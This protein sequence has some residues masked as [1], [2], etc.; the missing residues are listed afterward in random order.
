MVSDSTENSPPASSTDCLHPYAC[1]VVAVAVEPQNQFL[2]G[3]PRA[4]VSRC[5][6]QCGTRFCTSSRRRTGSRGILVDVG[7]NGLGKWLMT[8]AAIAD[9]KKNLGTE[10]PICHARGSRHCRSGGKRCISLRAEECPS[11]ARKHSSASP[12]SEAASWHSTLKTPQY[13]QRVGNCQPH[14]HLCVRGW[15]LQILRLSSALNSV[16]AISDCRGWKSAGRP[17]IAGRS[18][19]KER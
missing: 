3:R 14:R 6:D 11:S 17:R 1:G 12:T 19:E 15:K 10:W 9:V 2:R 8:G 5:H 13:T 7:D 16:T 18:S 4:S